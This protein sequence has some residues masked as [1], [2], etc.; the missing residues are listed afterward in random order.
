MV[1]EAKIPMMHNL[2]VSAYTSQ[3]WFDLEQKHI[4]STTWQFLGFI[5]EFKKPGNYMCLDI[6]YNSFLVVMDNNYE[7]KA[8]H[9]YCSTCKTPIL[10]NFGRLGKYIYCP[11]KNVTYDLEGNSTNANF[12]SLTIASIGVF[13]G[14]YFIHPNPNE[15]INDFFGEVLPYLGPHKVEK[16]VEYSKPEEIYVKEVN[17]NWKI[18]VE[19]Y[20]D[21]YHLAHLHSGTLN[22]YQ[23]DKAE[24]GWVG[25]HYWFYE[26][27][28]EEYHEK[29]DSVSEYPLIDSV[30]KEAIGGYVPWLFPNIGLSE[31]EN[32][33][34][35]FH[36]TPISPSKTLVT[37]RS[38]LMNLPTK[39]F[40]K[41][42]NKS[43]AEEEFWNRRIFPKYEAH[44]EGDPMATADFME[45]DV[46]VCEQQQKS[47][48]S[49][50]FSVG[51]Q[52][53]KGE[54]AVAKFQQVVKEWIEKQRTLP[55]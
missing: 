22:M 42:A 12:P 16:L 4:F 18:I 23:H 14:M 43:Y 49:P 52:A 10:K 2:P 19:N 24:F 55:K 40:T 21:Q 38:K 39:E 46:Y 28:E 50:K 26:P 20:I 15:D 25:P 48:Q 33:W 13:K 17:C 35:A 44:F 36:V 34:T 53:E 29:L 47:L 51:A 3:K 54:F 11:T 6:G 37:L 1:A 8:F 41:Q 30:P 45:E 27:L 31:E 32:S 7:V 9:N 5:E